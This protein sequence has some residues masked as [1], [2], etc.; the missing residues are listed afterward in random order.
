MKREVTKDV[1]GTIRKLFCSRIIHRF[2]LMT[3]SETMVIY[4]YFKK[5]CGITT[6]LKCT[7]KYLWN[8][9]YYSTN[10]Y[11]YEGLE[12]FFNSSC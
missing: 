2:L 9:Y 5:L 7:L 6:F 11:S 12:I 1:D 8:R 3:T 4:I 10:P